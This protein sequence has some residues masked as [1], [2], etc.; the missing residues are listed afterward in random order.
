MVQAFFLKMKRGNPSCGSGLQH[1]KKEPVGLQM[2]H[3]R[4]QI[5]NIYSSN[6]VTSKKITK[7]Y[8]V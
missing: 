2:A 5:K 4:A 7:L 6:Y 3:R 8:N 1:T